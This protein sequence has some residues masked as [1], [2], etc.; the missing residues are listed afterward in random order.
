M[1]VR[2]SQMKFEVTI[3]GC[4]AATPTLKRNPTSQLINIH[5][6]YMLLDCSE[7]TQ[8]QLRKQKFKFQRI[9][10]IFIS[11][12]HGD[13]Y[14]GLPGLVSSMHLL[15]RAKELHIYCPA[16]LQELLEL[17][18][19]HSD[20]FLNFK[21]IYHHND[22]KAPQMVFEDKGIEVWSFPLKHRI[23]CTGFKFLEKPKRRRLSK[24]MIIAKELSVPEIVALKNGED[25]VRED[26][27]TISAATTTLEPSPSRMYAYCSDTAYLEKIVPIIEGATLLYHEATFLESHAERA[28]KTFHSTAKQAA[29][30][31]KMANAKK[32]VLGHYSSRY[33]DISDFKTEAVEVFENVYLAH[34]G[35][36]FEL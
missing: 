4:G 29:K 33:R 19:K 10:H 15:G 14:L 31:A 3:L 5:D 22:F 7:G 8:L 26:K 34:D 24:E 2:I 18:L 17:N 12:L 25:V 11:H 35:I 6:K 36:T 30:I 23:P 20:T 16:P 9:N 27:S 28:K 1:P 21:I 13:H 32:L